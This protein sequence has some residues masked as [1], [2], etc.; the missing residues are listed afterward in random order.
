MASEQKTSSDM[1]VSGNYFSECLAELR[2]V[3]TPTK[4]EALQATMVTLIIITF[5][6]V[7]LFVMDYL[8]HT[9]VSMLVL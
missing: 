3:A 6:S 1:T 2:K 4:Q 9:L 5:M 7:C 8:F